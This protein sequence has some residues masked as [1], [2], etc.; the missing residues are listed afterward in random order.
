MGLVHQQ[1]LSDYWSTDP[2][3]STPFFPTVMPRDRFL[4][5]LTFLH[6]SDNS[7]YI[8]RG[9]DGYDPLYKLGTIYHDITHLFTT[10]YY[11][12]KNIAIDEGL[13]PWRG[14][15]HFRVYNPDKPDKFG[16]KSYQLCD[17]TG[18]CCKY[19]IYT[20]KRPG[21]SQHGATYDLCMRL[22]ENYLNRGHHL[23][24]DNFY[25]SPVLLS[26]LYQQGTGACGTLRTNRKH[27]P[28]AIKEG[29]PAKGDMIVVH[30]SPLIVMKYHDK[31]QVSM[32]STLH[33]G[34]M[35]PSGKVDRETKEDIMK[36][37]AIL[38]YNKFMGS[39]DR[40]DQL[41]QYLAMRRRTLKWYKKVMF[42][43]LDLCVVQAYLIYKQQTTGRPVLHR[44]FKR[45]L[46][47]QM[48]QPLQLP[49][50]VNVGRPRSDPNALLRLNNDINI[51]HLELIV[52]TGKKKSR[53][54]RG[55]A[56]CF[57]GERK[58]L[59]SLNQPVPKRPG[60]ESCYECPGCD[61]ALCVTPC[62]RIYHTKVDIYAAYL[63][64]KEEQ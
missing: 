57:F 38:D 49:A 14:N 24:I 37:D 48:L 32:C 21:G 50:V 63:K 11:P 8:A 17:E 40:S 5:L 52:G 59:E 9:N 39:V 16:I 13:V 27:V 53:V 45:E 46:V 10:N 29:K 23:Y 51:H 19:E 2:V 58:R 30:N 15:I 3:I 44:V 55:C 31:R 28:E 7:N 22:M 25:T 6:Y 1:D 61:V 4:L 41:V 33:R 60:R 12:T 20:G 47:K 35:V 62:Y 18:Y 26:H 42:H 54:S 56:V 34:V 36:P 64:W 43:L